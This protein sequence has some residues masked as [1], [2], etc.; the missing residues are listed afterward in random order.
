MTQTT[1]SAV[2][3]LTAFLGAVSLA[4]A[5]LDAVRPEQHVLPTPCETYDVRELSRHV[6][7]VLRRVAEIGR[8]GDPM[9]LPDVADGS[10][11]EAAAEASDV[12]SADPG[13]LDRSVRMPF[14]TLPG[15]AA[16][17]AYATEFTLHTWDLAVATG[18]SPDWDPRILAA[19]VSAMRRALPAER[20]GDG[21]PF[22]TVI[23]TAPDAP[24]I[25]RL[26]AWYG[27]RPD[28]ARDPRSV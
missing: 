1:V 7:A 22:G 15:S 3:P 23:E 4:G 13:L 20:R 6:V 17:V 19:L 18:Q 21:V 28:L 8:G 25:D 9:E 24:A 26:V 14:G 11:R 10:W 16:L 27:R 2:D 5:T 12:W